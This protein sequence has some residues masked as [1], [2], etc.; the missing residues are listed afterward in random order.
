MRPRSWASGRRWP[1][2]ES[3]PE[4]F[5]IHP[6]CCE[7]PYTL[8]LNSVIGGSSNHCSHLERLVSLLD[9]SGDSRSATRARKVV[10]NPIGN[11]HSSPI[12][13]PS[14]EGFGSKF[15]QDPGIFAFRILH[16]RPA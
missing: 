6:D 15:S 5:S 1:P 2:P 8:L 14:G 12:A 9:S 10:Q 11:S 4:E 3:L 13:Q 16:A 7:C